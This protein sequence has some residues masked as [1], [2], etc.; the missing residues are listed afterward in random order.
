M[1]QDT[2]KIVNAILYS[3]RPSATLGACLLVLAAY[4]PVQN[5]VTLILPLMLASFF[6]GSFCFLINDI[7]DR[8]KDLLNNKK[9]PIATGLIPIR[10][11][12]GT[13]IVCAVIFL[14]STWYIGL[15]AFIL[16]FGFLFI[17][18][19]YSAINAKT[20]LFANVI[21]ALM[22]SGTQWGVAIIQPDAFLIM[23]S[24]FL[25]FLTIPREILLDWLDLIGDKKSG[26][27]SFPMSHSARDTKW[28]IAICLPIC[29]GSVYPLLSNYEWI[30]VTFYLIAI[31]TSWLSFV[32][33]MKK[34]SNNTA[35]RGVRLTHIS[36]AFLILALFSR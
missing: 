34:A 3:I 22:V 36:F 29:S 16:S 6:G 26:K 7:Y 11:V 8:E 15:Y 35:L 28:L 23:S 17:A 5:E 19:A 2:F 20:G 31:V 12:V 27:Q 32:P 14:I 4:N 18:T 9:R 25:F 21:V 30:S 1:L 10:L 33:F 13:S 24:V